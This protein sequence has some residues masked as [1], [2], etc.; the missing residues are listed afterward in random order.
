M[1]LY[2][3]QRREW[4]EILKQ[5]TVPAFNKTL[6]C[7]TDHIDRSSYITH[8]VANEMKATDARKK[9]IYS[10]SGGGSD[11]GGAAGVGPLKSNT[12][13]KPILLCVTWRTF[14]KVN[15]NRSGGVAG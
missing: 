4:N 14:T 11:A 3:Q 1:V 5:R 12:N 10:S 13:S 6:L 15:G 9:I 8:T 2:K 7:W